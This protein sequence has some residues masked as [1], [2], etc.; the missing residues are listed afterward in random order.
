MILESGKNMA[1]RKQVS[2]LETCIEETLTL[3]K[4]RG[5]ITE[6]ILF[7]KYQKEAITTAFNGEDGLVVLPS[8][9]L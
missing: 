4:T 8:V 3:L 6:N 7:M 5:V 2:N 9:A 1:N